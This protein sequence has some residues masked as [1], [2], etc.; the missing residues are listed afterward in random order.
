M[1]S[2][3]QYLVRD[4]NIISTHI[5]TIRGIGSICCALYERGWELSVCARTTQCVN[6]ERRRYSISSRSLPL[7]P[8]ACNVSCDVKHTSRAGCNKT[9]ARHDLTGHLPH[10][11]TTPT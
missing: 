4:P 1:V 5:L 6:S 7:T 10:P 11:T 9:A 2:Q 3:V 8:P